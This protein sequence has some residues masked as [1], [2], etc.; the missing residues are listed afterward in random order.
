MFRT[1]S[2]PLKLVTPV[3]RAIASIDPDQ[4]IHAVGTLASQTALAVRGFSIIGVMAAIFAGITLFLG[5]LGVYGV[6]SQAV[7]RRTREFGI[8]VALGATL[9]QVLRL[10]LLQGGRQIAA[11][12]MVGLAAGFFLTRPLQNLFGSQMANN[13]AV[14]LLILSVEH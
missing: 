13:P 14:Y 10:V 6:T 5:A 9:G 3:R 12:V 7:S 1:K 4:P 2:D 11:G 8:R